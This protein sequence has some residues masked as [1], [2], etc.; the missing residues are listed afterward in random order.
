V[1]DLLQQVPGEAIRMALLS[2]HYRGPMD[3]TE[4]GVAQA[5]RSLDRL[6]QALRDM[7]DVPIAA[8]VSRSAPE[9]FLDC[10]RDDL[11]TPKAL[12]VLFG[13]AHEAHTAADDSDRA[14]IKSAMLAAGD[15]LG[16]L[17]QEPEAWFAGADRGLD[18]Q[19]IERLIEARE[20]ARSAGDFQTAD[21]IRNE[22]TE[23]GI[24]L[25]DGAGGTRWR[26][27]T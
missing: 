9:A 21:R 2:A 4:E 24:V 1:H 23:Q 5:R 26:V 6:Y 10:L 18:T 7:Q 22:L 13:L 16:I 3:W 8:D 17:R 15:L 12:A 11:N 25:E 20:V 27:T 14:R 19:E